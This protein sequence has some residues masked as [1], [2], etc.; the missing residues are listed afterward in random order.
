MSRRVAVGVGIG[1]A[2]LV[3]VA[4]VVVAAMGW[5]LVGLADEVNDT[6]LADFTGFVEFADDPSAAPHPRSHRQ[7]PARKDDR[8]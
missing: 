6:E 8:A 3:V 4:G 7:T 5:W 1:A 2:V